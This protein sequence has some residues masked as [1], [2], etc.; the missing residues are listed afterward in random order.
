MG[1]LFKSSSFV[2]LDIIFPHVIELPPTPKTLEFLFIGRP[3]NLTEL[4]C[5]SACALLINS[6]LS[7]SKIFKFD[8]YLKRK[9]EIDMPIIPA[10]II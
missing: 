2:I 5:F 10:P 3:L 8:L 6:P 1:H 7:I 4:F 9:L